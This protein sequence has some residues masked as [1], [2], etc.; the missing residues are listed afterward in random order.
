[1]ATYQVFTRRSMAD[2]PT[3]KGQLIP[4]WGRKSIITYVNDADEARYIC[5]QYNNS[6]K[7]GK[8]RVMAEFTSSY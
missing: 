3:K 8:Y 4:K 2:H 1:M 7:P 5:A 6:H